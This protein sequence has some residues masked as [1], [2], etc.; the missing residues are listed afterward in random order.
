MLH[1]LQTDNYSYMKLLHHLKTP[2]MLPQQNKK[3]SA[4]SFIIQNCFRIQNEN[5]L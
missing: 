1:P 3:T 5:I 2:F 4:P